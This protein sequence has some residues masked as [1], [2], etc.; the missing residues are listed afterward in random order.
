MFE[1]ARQ[2]YN[3]TLRT[4]DRLLTDA[5]VIA[6][7]W[8]FNSI[9]D[10]TWTS[11]TAQQTD[12]DFHRD[13]KSYD[14]NEVWTQSAYATVAMVAGIVPLLII[15]NIQCG[16]PAFVK[17]KHLLAQ[18]LIFITAASLAIPAWDWGAHVGTEFFEQWLNQDSAS[19]LAF[20]FTGGFEGPIQILAA[21]L[22]TLFFSKYLPSAEIGPIASNKHDALR[23]L[24]V[25]LLPGLIPGGAWQLVYVRSALKKFS[26]TAISTFVMLAV[27]AANVVHGFFLAPLF[28][29]LYSKL[30][31]L[32][33]A[34][35]GKADGPGLFAAETPGATTPLTALINPTPASP[36]A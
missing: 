28:N 26:P 12:F 10:F 34:S 21:M 14:A 8:F 9:R 24:L 18:S 20:L 6:L 27:G 13:L 19:Y 22:G 36:T 3:N 31:C 2:L 11:L 4:K 7:I 5:G 29:A 30:R 32:S 35:R 15:N 25:G 23:E 33:V 16:K 1:A 17:N